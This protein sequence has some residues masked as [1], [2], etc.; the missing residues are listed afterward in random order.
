MSYRF[1]TAR[2]QFER[3]RRRGEVDGGQTT[4]YPHCPHRHLLRTAH[5]TI[6]AE[7]RGVRTGPATGTKEIQKADFGQ[8]SANSRPNSWV[9]GLHKTDLEKGA[10]V[11]HVRSVIRMLSRVWGSIA[12]YPRPVLLRV[13]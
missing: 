13:R 2:D 6:G 11:A 12:R 9:P 8:Q 5:S 1:R 3:T 10:T 4:P 7:G